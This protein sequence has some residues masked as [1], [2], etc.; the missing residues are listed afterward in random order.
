MN[1]ISSSSELTGRALPAMIDV[2]DWQ[3][4]FQ[5][6]AGFAHNSHHN[7][8]LYLSR[9]VQATYASNIPKMFTS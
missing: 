1:S 3:S 6:T 8:L 9:I 5:E 2:E 7:A 4:P